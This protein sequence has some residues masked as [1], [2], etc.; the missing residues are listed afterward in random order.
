M[1]IDVTFHPIRDS[2]LR[3]YVLDVGADGALATTRAIEAVEDDAK[4]DALIGIYEALASAGA[5]A[6]SGAGSI[7]MVVHY[8][9]AV[10]G[11]LHPYWYARGAGV[12]HLAEEDGELFGGLLAPLAA[13]AA[14]DE[15]GAPLGAAIGVSVEDM[16]FGAGY[17][18]NERLD[19]LED[20]LDG[21][22]AELAE[23]V[24]GEDGLAA[25]LAAIRYASLHNC[26]L[27][28]T[29]DVVALSEEE[30]I[31]DPANLRAPYLENAEDFANARTGLRRH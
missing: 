1:S 17:V 20:A 21:D 18:P 28:E 16:P 19:A 2:E 11:Y 26:G 31:S 10:A 9:A 15:D 22:G 4:Q 30:N 12:W 24:L 7:A 14:E 8:G 6:A 3:H 29:A 25:L 13:V 27:L 5:D 23:A